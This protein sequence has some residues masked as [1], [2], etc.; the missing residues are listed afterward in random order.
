MCDV[1]EALVKKETIYAGTKYIPLTPGTKIK[2]HYQTKRADNE[3]VIDD[4]RKDLKPMELVLGKKFKLEVWEVIVQ[5]MSLNEVAKFTVD[6]SLVPQY[7]F[8]SKTIRDTFKKPEERKHCCGMTLQNEGIGYHDL[9]DLF[10]QPCD[11]IFT[12]EVLSID[13][14]EQYEKESWQLSEPEKLKSI[15]EQR[16]KGNEYFKN[17]QLNEAEDAYSK[18]LGIVEQ[19]MLKE[20]PKDIEWNALAKLKVPLLLNYSQCKLVQKEYYR[21]IECC[22]EVLS[23]EPDNLKALYR[24]AKGHVG[25]WNPD[26]AQDDFQRCAELDPS[27]KAT[28]TKEI[29]SLKEKIKSYEDQNKSNFR[30]LF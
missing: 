14:P 11:L 10:K 20:K 8:V 6:K 29:N 1:D 17:N 18:A 15:D 5:K 22:T 4:S 19:L 25:A 24:R 13:L 28:V 23:Y 3:K 9:D 16:V 12:I 26:Q 7:P 21:V 30:K 27:L 2:F